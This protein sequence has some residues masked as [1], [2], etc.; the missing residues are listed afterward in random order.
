MTLFC[1]LL[2]HVAMDTHYR[3]QGLDFAL[4][5]RCAGDLIRREGADWEPLPRGTRVAWQH[6][7]QGSD[8]ASVATRMMRPPPPRRFLGRPAGGFDVRQRG[9]SGERKFGAG[10]DLLRLGGR[11]ALAKVAERLR[12][13]AAAERA[14]EPQII[15]LPAQPQ[16]LK[17]RVWRRSRSYRGWWRVQGAAP[18]L[19]VRGESS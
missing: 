17:A 13:P 10:M 3:N 6:S 11:I 9:K 7:G 14:G 4:C 18:G 19:R 1:R 12:T 15:Y 5:A 16:P 2:G 8:A